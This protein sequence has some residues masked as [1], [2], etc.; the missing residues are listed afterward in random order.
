MRKGSLMSSTQGKGLV[1]IY[2]KQRAASC[3]VRALAAAAPIR[4]K[5]LCSVFHRK[6]SEAEQSAP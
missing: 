2:S 4:S 5:S 3:A 6:R 1:G